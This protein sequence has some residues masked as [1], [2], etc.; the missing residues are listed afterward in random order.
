[1][2]STAEIIHEAETLPVEERAL[3]VDSLLRSLNQPDP[4]VDRKWTVVA[5]R[6]LEELRS[7]HVKPI[8]GDQVF[9][10]I[11]RRFAT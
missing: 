4:E 8:P 10:N 7:G 9:A 11:R 5:K 3:V 2:P 6:R 1:M